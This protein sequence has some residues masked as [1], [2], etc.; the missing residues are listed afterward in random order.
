[1]RL[2]IAGIT[3][4]PETFIDRLIDGLAQAGVEVTVGSANRPRGKGDSVRWLRTP[5]WDVSGPVRLVRLAVAADRATVSGRRDVKSFVPFV[6]Q[7][8]GFAQRLRVWNQLV[9]YAGLRWDVIYF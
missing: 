4:P 6:R 3:W 5:S 1:M 8:S 9:P 2:L 7:S